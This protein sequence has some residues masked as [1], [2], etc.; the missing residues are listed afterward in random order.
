MLP[1]KFLLLNLYYYGTCPYR[2][3]YAR[4][5]AARG[6][7]PVVVLFYHRVCDDHANDWT[8]SNAAFDRHLDWLQRHVDLVSLEEA[9]Q[10]IGAAGNT[11]P[12]V[13]L[14]FDDGYAENCQ[15]AIP[16]LARE[17]IPCTYFVTLHNV[18]TGE[19]FQHDAKAGF[20]G[21]PNTLAQLRDMAGAGIEIGAH[22]YTHP[23]FSRVRD[24]HV[25]HREVVVAREELSELLGRPVRYFAVP[26]GMHPQLSSALFEVA[27]Q[28]GYD[29]VC[30]G[31]G[32]YNFPGDDPFHLQRIAV[33]DELLRLK[34]RVTID[35]RKLFTPRFEPRLEVREPCAAAGN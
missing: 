27:R 29:A 17:K 20:R 24:P 6:R 9:Q 3:W 11:R 26:I 32:G 10:R 22:T 5:A 33:D 7:M 8:T 2:W 35:P 16:R 25:L 34:N 4:T 12:C 31:Y 1:A 13:S 19:P 30:S 23:D 15:H 18:L 28:A 21:T 14:T